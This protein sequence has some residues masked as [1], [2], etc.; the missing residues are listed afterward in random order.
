M[1][2]T[3]VATTSF[4]NTTKIV[5]DEDKCQ[6]QLLFSPVALYLLGSPVA[7]FV[8]IRNQGKGL[9]KEYK[10]PTC[11]RVLNIFHPLDPVAYR[12]EPLIDP[13]FKSFTPVVIAHSKGLKLLYQVQQ[14]SETISQGFKALNNIFQWSSSRTNNIGISDA[15]SGSGTGGSSDKTD[16]N[17]QGVEAASLKGVYL[18]REK[19]IDYAL[20]EGALESTAGY[21]SALSCHIGYFEDKDIARYVSVYCML[22]KLYLT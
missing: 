16:A 2:S 13:S 21:L 5:E 4:T 6:F 17:K 9:P 8:T 19:R 14:M 7:L 22:N 11:P 15:G 12:I 20:Q 18:N 3:A 10:L 1:L